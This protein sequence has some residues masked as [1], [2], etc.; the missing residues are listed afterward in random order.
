MKIKMKIISAAAALLI[1]SGCEKNIE[2]AG[3]ADGAISDTETGFILTTFNTNTDTS[4]GTSAAENT[5]TET[6]TDITPSETR[7]NTGTSQTVSSSSAT[8]EKTSAVT[9]GSEIISLTP[10]EITAAATAAPAETVTAAKNQNRG[11]D[12][13]ADIC[14]SKLYFGMTAEEAAAVID[15]EADTIAGVTE[16]YSNVSFDLDESFCEGYI[17]YK[18][19]ICQIVMNTL[20]MSQNDA[21]DLRESLIKKLNGI[22]SLSDNNWD[23]GMKEND[24]CLVNGIITLELTVNKAG[25]NALVALSVTSPK[26]IGGGDIDDIS[27]FPPN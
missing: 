22:Y 5:D 11:L 7:G 21:L 27:V 15:A 23:V 17:V 24:I 6:E 25:E 9:T 19:G 14:L 13:S 1:L 20:F 16:F 4:A 10:S 12:S 26:H 2:D 18:N 3:S 8:A